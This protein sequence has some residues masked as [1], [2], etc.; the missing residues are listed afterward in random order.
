[1]TLTLADDLDDPD[2]LKMYVHTGNEVSRSRLSKV[3]RHT[4]R[5]TDVT[6]YITTPHLQVAVSQSDEN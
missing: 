2:I 6:D 1:V 3:R 5:Q 4:D